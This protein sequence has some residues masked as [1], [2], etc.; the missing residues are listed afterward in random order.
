[1]SVTPSPVL[2]LPPACQTGVLPVSTLAP[3][4]Q[5]PVQSPTARSRV[6]PACAS[7]AA[8][9]RSR[10]CGGHKGTGAATWT[11]DQSTRDAVRRQW[12][13]EPASAGRRKAVESTRQV[14]LTRAFNN[15]GNASGFGSG[16][17]V[18]PPPPPRGVM[19]STSALQKGRCHPP[20]TTET[21]RNQF[22]CTGTS[23]KD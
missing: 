16:H 17:A 2:C 12:R 1:M 10:R 21:P 5:Q 9:S 20:W 19:A 23:H 18:R 11:C 7:I 13:T 4:L 8:N 14:R 22:L 15:R 3:F 6:P